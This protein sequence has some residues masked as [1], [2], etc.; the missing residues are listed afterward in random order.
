MSIR[1][2][3]QCEYD[4]HVKDELAGKT[5][6]CP[7][8]GDAVSV[9]G[10]TSTPA[11]AKR[12]KR[13]VKSAKAE[14]AKQ[15]QSREDEFD[16]EPRSTR[17]DSRREKPKRNSKPVKQGVSPAMLWGGIAGGVAVGVIVALFFV[18]GG[19]DK[20]TE[21]SVANDHPDSNQLA[22]DSNNTAFNAPETQPDAATNPNANPNVAAASPDSSSAPG[23]GPVNS[24]ATPGAAGPTVTQ[25]FSSRSP[26]TPQPV[27]S[28]PTTTTTPATT[29]ATLGIGE[30]PPKASSTPATPSGARKTYTNLADLIEVIEP[31]V[32]RINVLTKESAGN[33]SGFVVD[34]AGTIVTN[35]HVIEGAIKATA[36]FADK[37]SA[38]IV[39]FYKVDPNR[40]IAVLKIDYPADKLKP[41]SLAKESPRKGEK[42]VAF[43]APLGLD[44]TATEGILSSVRTN[45]E[46]EELGRRGQLGDWLQTTAPISPGNSGGPLV[47]MKGEVVGAN[48]LTL[49]IGQNLN[50]AISSMDIQCTVDTRGTKL[51]EIH[52]DKLPEAKRPSSGGRELIVDALESARAKKLLAEMKE[53][54][55]V[56][57]AFALDPTRRVALMVSTKAENAAEKAG[58]V[59]GDKRE[60]GFMLVT[61]DLEDTSGTAGTQQLVI[62][63]HILI[64]DQNERGQL[65]LVKIWEQKEKV[66]TVSAQALARGIVP[67]KMDEKV[68]EFFRGF[69]S[70][71]RRAQREA[72]KK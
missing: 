57:A 59:V 42:V 66:G 48:T 51:T 56:V 39:G 58:L 16:D 43:G 23:L 7:E 25:D 68:S 47:N 40:D 64:K 20:S 10:G 72:E 60:R 21:N 30:A 27:T 71:F 28:N 67:R 34:K 15:R 13:A 22:D 8:C 38:P 61:M 36:H 11:P 5:I 54:T 18:L 2:V 6:R 46:M 19:D 55:F 37:T 45:T 50:F 24:F 9:A 31:S 35:Y 33:G 41:I 3:C 69:V 53:I 29:V 14:P 44:F 17:R 70:D 32:V 4:F 65:E 1:V 26:S 49:T 52:P 12:K 63:A 62:S